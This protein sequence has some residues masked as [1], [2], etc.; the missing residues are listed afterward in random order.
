MCGLPTKTVS[1]SNDGCSEGIFPSQ[2][3]KQLDGTF[4][5]CW[6]DGCNNS[7]NIMPYNV[8]QMLLLLIVHIL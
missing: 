2:N 8:Q 1:K 7:I 4:C 6:N 5:E 3:G